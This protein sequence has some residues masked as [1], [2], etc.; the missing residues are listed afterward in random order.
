MYIG[1]LSFFF[2]N[3]ALDFAKVKSWSAVSQIIVHHFSDTTSICSLIHIPSLHGY[4]CVC[5]WGL[6][7]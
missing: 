5:V 6:R 2:F 1:I 4:V 3:L 7:I